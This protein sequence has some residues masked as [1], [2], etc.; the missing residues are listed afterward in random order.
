MI[1][2]VATFVDVTAERASEAARADSEARLRA[3]LEATTDGVFVLDR[4]GRI[5][6]LNDAARALLRDAPLDIESV[7]GTDAS[8][9]ELPCWT[10]YREAL[11]KD[12]PAEIEARYEPLD[13]VFRA[14][15]FPSG[16]TVTIFFQDVSDEA[17]VEQLRRDFTGELVHRIGN[18]FTLVSSMIKLSARSADTPAEA[19]KALEARVSALAKAHALARPQ[20]DDSA[21][22]GTTLDALITTLL[23]PHLAEGAGVAEVK[24]PAA[25][26]GPHTTTTFAM[27]LHELATNSAKYGALGAEGGRLEIVAAAEDGVMR[28]DWREYAPHPIAPPGDKRGFGAQLVDST[29]KLRLRGSIERDWREDGLS[30]VIHAPL[31][32]LSR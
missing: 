20:L 18:I 4:N 25:P 22:T 27:A 21:Q 2:A 30:V 26:I 10:A 13:R 29:V 31:S 3:A 19:A 1:A 24:A 32:M 15:A 23:A 16:E 17:A 28:I 8:G 7:A 12:A 11:G 5:L 6:F 14:R 9:A